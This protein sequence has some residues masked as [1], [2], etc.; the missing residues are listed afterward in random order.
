MS[1]S[2]SSRGMD[3]HGEWKGASINF[4]GQWIRPI[5]EDVWRAGPGLRF[6]LCFIGKSREA[7]RILQGASRLAWGCEAGTPKCQ[8]PP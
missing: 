4:C 1:K 6:S 5:P 8:D 3:Q 2:G 7:S